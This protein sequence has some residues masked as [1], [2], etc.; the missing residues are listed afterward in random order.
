MRVQSIILLLCISA[1][2]CSKSAPAP[3]QATSSESASPAVAA[4]PDATTS[5]GVKP[6]PD[7]DPKLAKQL[8]SDGALL[9][10]VR[11]QEEWDE[12]HLDGATLIPVGE[13]DGRLAEVDKATGGDKNK[14]IVVYCRSGGRAGQAKKMLESAGYTQ[15]TNMGGIADWPS[16]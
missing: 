8:V 13:L 6:L 3:Q 7:R 4:S 2:G 5:P 15:V 14:A 11:S 16:D 10:D 9:L 1:L 12:K